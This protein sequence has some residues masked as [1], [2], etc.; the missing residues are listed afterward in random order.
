MEAILTP[1]RRGR[2]VGA[3]CLLLAAALAVGC[4]DQD[5]S[6][7][8][9]RIR[10][11]QDAARHGGGDAVSR[12]EQAVADDDAAV[13]VEAALAL[14]RMREDAARAAL[15][16]VAGNEKRQDVRAAATRAL[17]SRLTGAADAE[18]AAVLRRVAS[19]DPAPAVRAE[20]A[21]S[22]GRIGSRDDVPF[23]ADLA[24]ADESVPVQSRAVGAI[25]ALTGY[26]F[27]YDSC[28]S[29]RQRRETLERL[30]EE[31]RR[32]AEFQDRFEQREAGG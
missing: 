18:S 4:G 11:I 27:P 23:L 17:G 2:W 29:D 7:R 19:A 22:L 6:A 21:A 14:G 24:A 16:R 9:A 5:E 15:R 26:R 25:E 28:A 30:K 1:V 32:I 12:L 10:E 20:A 31:A 3:W 8:T 13:A